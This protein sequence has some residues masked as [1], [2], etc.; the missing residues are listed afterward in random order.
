MKLKADTFRLRQALW[1]R[2]A[3]LR[4]YLTFNVGTGQLGRR[5]RPPKGL[6]SVRNQYAWFRRGL[7]GDALFFQVGRF[8]AFY[9]PMDDP[10]AIGLGLQPLKANRR[11]AR[12]GFPLE[13]ARR[14]ARAL[15][16]AGRAVVVVEQTEQV[17]IE[18]RERRVRWRL[19]PKC[20]PPGCH[21][22]FKTQYEG[23][24][25]PFLERIR[26]WNFFVPAILF[27]HR[28]FGTFKRRIATGA[29]TVCPPW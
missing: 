22:E 26:A 9:A 15:L 2:Y 20:P 5:D 6:T 19:E 14:Y 1:A 16:K 8:F 27:C 23:S 29:V 28:T 10:I 21:G 13:L 7:P 11:R 18:I 24:R 3:F 25:R 4:Q 12:Y 17:W